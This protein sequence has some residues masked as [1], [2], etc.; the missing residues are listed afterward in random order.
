MKSK[1]K[2]ENRFH[3]LTIFGTRPE[4]IKM[5]LLAKKLSTITC[6]KHTVCVTAQHREMLDQ[7]LEYF[8]IKPD[9][10]LDLMQPN[11]SLSDFAARS[12]SAISEL[13]EKLKPDLVLVHGDTSTSFVATLAA[14]YQQIQVA[15]VEAGMRTYNLKAP[16]PEELNRTL[17][18][19]IASIHFAATKKNRENLLKENIAS[20]NILVCGNTVIDALIYTSK[21]V[22]KITSSPDAEFIHQCIKSKKKIIL[23]TGHRRENF[24]EGFLEICKALKSIAQAYSDVQI[25]YPIHYNPSIKNIVIEF[26]SG[27]K[28]ILLTSAFNYPDFVFLM[29]HAWII[30]TDSGGVQEEAPS[31]GKPVLVMREITER[32]EAVDAGT[33]LLTGASEKKIIKA[34]KKLYSDKNV[35]Q[36]MAKAINPYGDG[37]ATN[38]IA[39]WIMNYAKKSM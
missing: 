1:N 5:A 20:K 16:F 10:D 13:F 2:N 24:G 18:A 39:K 31:L 34:V 33:V 12:L 9:Y 27:E 25:I 15:H 6:I 4:A 35:Y 28:N 30:L 29:K 23:V 3:V 7:V 36:K 8:S 32:P 26:L 37:K 21:K 19:K 11:Q 22:K 14:F 38:R 17:T